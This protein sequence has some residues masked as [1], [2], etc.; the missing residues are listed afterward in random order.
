MLV[1]PYITAEIQKLKIEGLQLFLKF[2]SL[3][4]AKRCIL[5]KRSCFGPQHGKRCLFVEQLQECIVMETYV[6]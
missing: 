1:D 6:K 2:I 4:L 5:Y 3:A